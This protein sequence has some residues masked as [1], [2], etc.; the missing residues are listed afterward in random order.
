MKPSTLVLSLL[1]GSGFASAQATTAAPLPA[2]A[3]AAATGAAANLPASEEMERA[4]LELAAARDELQRASEQFARAS[5]QL[6]QQ[7]ARAYAYRFISDE[8][9]AALGI[10]IMDEEGKGAVRGVRVA[11]VSPGSGADKAGIRS[12]DLLLRANGTDL[13]AR[14]GDESSTR[15]LE[16]MEKL[17]PGAEVRLE[18]EREGKSATA[19]AVA[20]RAAD[21][22]GSLRW[23][24][25]EKDDVLSPLPPVPS[26]PPLPLLPPAATLPRVPT[27]PPIAAMFAGLGDLD[28]Q[29]ASLD[30]DLAPYFDTD[31]GVVVVRA[32][33]ESALALKSGDVIQRID[34]TAV[35]GPQ[36]V[37]ER[38]GEAGKSVRLE[39]VRRGKKQTVN[40]QVPE[41]LATAWT[42]PAAMPAP[43]APPAAPN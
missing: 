40:G 4:R 29:L 26:L 7:S 12:G 30:T 36:D 20:Q 42:M 35:A 27:V 22:F 6:G 2:T 9:R 18:Y 33:K 23:R 38:L 21:T 19:T 41:R 25:D 15:L 13:G 3:A 37:L 28:F 31:R 1:L 10:G 5:A 43:P 17:K 32:P 11:S 34:G 24:D 16:I 39:I 14:D 8:N